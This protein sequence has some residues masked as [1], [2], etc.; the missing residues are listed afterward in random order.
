MPLDQPQAT[1]APTAAVVRAGK[2]EALSAHFTAIARGTSDRH[3]AQ[4]DAIFVFLVRATSAAILYVSQ[5]I[6]AR[7]MGAADYGIYVWVWTLV[8]VLGGISHLGVGPSLVRLLPMYRETGQMDLFRGLMIGSRWLAFVCGS[9][10]SFTAYWALRTF[11]SDID[12]VYLL[13]AMLGTVCIPLFAMTDL[14]DGLGRAQGWMAVALVPPYILRPL[15]LL[16][17]MAIAHAAGFP[18]DA[19]TATLAAIIACWASSMVQT[20]MVQQRLDSEVEKGPRTYA[21]PVWVKSSLPLL[22]IY[23]SELVLQNTDVLVLSAYLPPQVVGMYFAAAKTMALVMFVHYAVGSAV[24][25]DFAALHARGDR[26]ALAA[27]ARD[28]VQ[29]TF[30]PSLAAT[31]AILALGKPLLWL[32][33]PSFTDA[34]PVMLVLA[35]GFMFRASVGPAEFVLNA[36]GEQ[37]RCAAVA[38]IAASI[39]IG[40]NLLLVPELGMMGA[41]IATASAL[42]TGAVLFAYVARQRTGLDLSI[43]QVM[44]PTRNV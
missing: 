5:I 19:I 27:Y 16:S 6:L 3:G 26:V 28:A 18:M 23:A 35:G 13:P 39:N 12:D 20:L 38:V 32:F 8:L 24:A 1:S 34:Y 37:K 44:R 29:W 2:F 15:A 41:A 31:L 40:L 43:L 17:T 10:V 42:A 14:Q 11:A 7:W 22:I 33:S 21:F 9:V 30:W 25:K 36:L 4:R